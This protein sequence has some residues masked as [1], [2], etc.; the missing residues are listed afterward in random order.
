MQILMVMD[1]QGIL[2]KNRDFWHSGE[3]HE[4]EDLLGEALVAEGRAVEVK[5]GDTVIL[6]EIAPVDL[7]V[8]KE[9]LTPKKSHA[10][11]SES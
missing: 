3:T 7:V 1:Y 10:K 5:A 11:K 2:L 6:D 9:V 8:M 4:V